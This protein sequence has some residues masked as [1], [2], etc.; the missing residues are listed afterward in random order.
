[1][2]GVSALWVA[3]LIQI[4]LKFEIP[5]ILYSIFTNYLCF[6]L[7]SP[8]PIYFKPI[9]NKLHKTNSLIFIK[10]EPL[11]ADSFNLGDCIDKG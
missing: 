3:K 7:F 2:E 10:D 11:V 1:M 8:K 9:I 6:C 5:I 4:V